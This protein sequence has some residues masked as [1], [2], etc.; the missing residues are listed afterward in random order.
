MTSA[1]LTDLLKS[2]GLLGL[3]LI[4]GT[5]IRAKI[6]IFQKTFIPASVIGGFLLLIL[7]PQVINILPVPDD[8]FKYYSMIPG[9]LIVP[10]VASVPLGLR[11]GKTGGSTDAGFMK[12]VVPLMFIGLGVSMMQ[13]GIGYLAHI[14][15]QGSFDFYDQFGIELPIGFVGG[16]G[17]AGTLGNTL[18]EMNLP[19]WETSQGVATTTATFGIVGGIII[20]IILINWAARH[21]QTAMLDKP[22]DIPEAFKVGFHKN[23]KEQGSL[24]RETTMSSSIDTLAFHTALIFIACGTAYLCVKGAKAA[25]IPVLKSISVWAYGMICMFIIW[26]ILCKLKMDYLVDG[27]VKSHISGAFTEFAV[28]GA[29][30]S[31][32]I[33]AVAAYLIPIITMVFIGYLV[34]AAWLVLLSRYLLKGY[35]FEQM[36]GTLGMATGVFITG[37]LLLRICDPDLKSPALASYSLSYTVTSVIYFA[38]LNM[39]IIMPTTHSVMMA[40]LTGF[41]IALACLIGAVISS[42]IAFGRIIPPPVK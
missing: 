14:L 2:L 25:S 30:A 17:T 9:I 39:F 26:G 23:M 8:W 28:I 41:G 13:F 29:V 5:L 27:A 42:R 33:K 1:M 4:I 16:H 34:T 18:K 21:G 10:V 19:Y 35:W 22:A 36:I 7:G 38:L 6:R 37:V 3:F 12:N 32:P 20:G 15:F 31:L 24:G 40:S 11:F